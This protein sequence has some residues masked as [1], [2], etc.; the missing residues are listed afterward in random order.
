MK[1]IAESL[2]SSK[3]CFSDPAALSKDT[4]FCIC[5]VYIQLCKAA[6]ALLLQTHLRHSV[7]NFIETF[8]LPFST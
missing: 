6:K 3:P 5:Y 2:L 8:L 4:Y 7:M 1:Y